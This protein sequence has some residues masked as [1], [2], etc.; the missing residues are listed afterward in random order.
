MH[1]YEAT[2]G[3][4]S[5]YSFAKCI[6]TCSTDTMFGFFCSGFLHLTQSQN[7][8]LFKHF[9][10]SFQAFPAPYDCGT[11]NISIQYILHILYTEYLTSL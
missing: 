2:D 1:N 8:A 5:G 4:I 6:K 10:G 3:L 11:L 9:Q 7:Q